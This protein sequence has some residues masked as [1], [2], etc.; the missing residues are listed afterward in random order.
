MFKYGTNGMRA[1]FAQLMDTYRSTGMAHGIKRQLEAESGRG[2]GK[3]V[4]GGPFPR[5]LQS[6]FYIYIE[7]MI[8]FKFQRETIKITSFR[9]EPFTNNLFP[10]HFMY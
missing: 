1:V 9:Q 3:K 2:K 6:F 4:G 10:I 5:N 8:K 7:N